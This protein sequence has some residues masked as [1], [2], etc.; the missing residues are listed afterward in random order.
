LSAIVIFIIYTLVGVSLA[1]PS[2]IRCARCAHLGASQA[3]KSGA[4]C[5]LMYNGQHCHHGHGH[6]SGK[7]TLCPDGCLRHDGQGGEIPSL[8]K[9]LSAPIH[10]SPLARLLGFASYEQPI[11]F[12]APFLAPPTHPPSARA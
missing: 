5:P 2:E 7:I 6:S 12:L 10:P 4:S 11:S 3:M 9:F 8:A 1:L